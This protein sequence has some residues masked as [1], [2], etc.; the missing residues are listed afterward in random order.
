MGLTA[1]GYPGFAMRCYWI[2]DE[3]VSQFQL[4]QYTWE[5]N[6]GLSWTTVICGRP[7]NT[8]QIWWWVNSLELLSPNGRCVMFNDLAYLL[9][10]LC[11][12]HNV[13]IKVLLV[14]YFGLIL[15]I[16]VSIC[17]HLWTRRIHCHFVCCSYSYGQRW[18]LLS[19]YNTFFLYTKHN[20]PISV[21]NR[22]SSHWFYVWK[23]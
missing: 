19:V 20:L 2:G 5:F 17:S 21:I 18:Q 22:S 7:G 23:M 12:W 15:R 10:G 6:W 9:P 4:V 1:S 11:D 8:G 13:L 14:N 3:R 16:G